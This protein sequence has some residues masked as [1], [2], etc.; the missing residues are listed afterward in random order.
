M[1]IEIDLNWKRKEI[2]CILIINPIATVP[3]KL[4]KENKFKYK[5]KY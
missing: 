5:S 4:L 1:I 3:I 2:E